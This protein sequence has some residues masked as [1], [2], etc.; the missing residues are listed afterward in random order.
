[1]SAEWPLEV[2]DAVDRWPKNKRELFSE[3]ME[4]AASDLQREFICRA[5][6]AGHSPSEVHAFADA[7][8]PLDDHACIDACVIDGQGKSMSQLLRAEA[9]PLYAF[10]LTGGD[11]TPA[12]DGV[13]SVA[14]V[15]TPVAVPRQAFTGD[16]V[17]AG[18]LAR[19]GAAFAADS[20]HVLPAVRA[21]ARD[22]TPTP[23]A[24]LKVESFVAE[25]TRT[26]GLSWTEVEVDVGGMTL[27]TALGEAAKALAS[28]LLVTV[29]IGP[30]AGQS[31]RH[32]LMLQLNTSGKARAWQLFDPFTREL[33]WA[34]QGDLVGRSE[35]PFADKRNR[36]ITRVAWPQR[37]GLAF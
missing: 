23:S 14:A 27:E 16:V 37:R 21:Q 22:S 6:V 32:V 2:F 9:D 35:L 31:R 10:R 17:A 30:A 24:A 33:V 3:L 13:G 25:A 26:L 1:V 19:G 36:R 5:V 15:P 12:D 4:D 11:L 29:A 28:G 34:N 8:R 20:A 18:K 7:L